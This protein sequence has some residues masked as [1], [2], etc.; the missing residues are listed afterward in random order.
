MWA[1]VQ[2]IAE[3]I[4]GIAP[5]G[6]ALEG[7][8]SGLQVGDP[9]ASVKNVLTALELDR[10]VLEEA[11]ACRADMIVTHHPLLYR[12]LK[13]LDRS[14]PEA[15][16]VAQII[17][18]NINVYSAHTNLD[19]AP[20]GVSHFLADRLGLSSDG[21]TVLEQTATDSL[22]KLVVFVPL[23]DADRLMAALTG[24]GAGWIGRYSH[25]TF[26]IKGT[27]T[28]LPRN[29]TRPVIGEQGRLERVEEIRL[30]TILPDSRR[31]AVLAA[32]MEAHPYEEVAYDLYPLKRPGIPI[33]LGVIGRLMQPVTLEQF[34]SR[35]LRELSPEM[36]RYWAPQGNTLLS[37]IAVCGGS[38]GRLVEMA[39]CSGAQLYLSGDFGYHD[40]LTAAGRGLALIDAGHYAT[41]A[42][43]VELLAAFLRRCL[44][45]GGFAT[46]VHS[47]AS[48]GKTRWS[49][50]S[51]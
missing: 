22:L 44:T 11:R 31:A 18:N 17:H 30:E 34:L 42:P 13:V 32:M 23:D 15:D 16:L 5:P 47:A 33:G 36:I 9:Q 45:R 7:D 12:P 29:G 3:M 10:A 51:R 48:G 1:K 21:R 49:L 4:E 19:V 37:R 46:I 50:C 38:G 43:V 2:Q 40:L 39:A 20:G 6:L 35:C 41:E 27:G 8:N 28:F 14:A 26:Q 25:C 24:A